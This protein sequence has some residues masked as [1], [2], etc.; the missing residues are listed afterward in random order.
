M[1]DPTYTL[2]GEGT[3]FAEPIECISAKI[4]NVQYLTWL[5]TLRVNNELPAITIQEIDKR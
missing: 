4:K 2:I 5:E 1:A 3:I